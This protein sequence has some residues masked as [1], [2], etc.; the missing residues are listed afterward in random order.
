MYQLISIVGMVILLFAYVM[1]LVGKMKQDTIIY[2]FLNALACAILLIYSI[3]MKSIAFIIL[4]IVWGMSGLITMI[5]L[6][7]KR[8]G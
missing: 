1:N 2:N 8:N 6:M 7:V 4:Q 3:K 5:R